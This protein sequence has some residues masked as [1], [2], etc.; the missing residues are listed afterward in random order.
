[1]AP[2]TPDTAAES[3]EAAGAPAAA[4]DDRAVAEVDGDQRQQESRGAD[5]TPAVAAP[6]AE[7]A[8]EPATTP[9]AES[10][11]EF[12]SVPP[13]GAARSSIVAPAP[14]AQQRRRVSAPIPR[15][16]RAMPA[17]AVQSGRTLA[18]VAATARVAEGPAT[19]RPAAQRAETV[20]EEAAAAASDAMEPSDEE[21]AMPAVVAE[22]QGEAAAP[23]SPQ[24]GQRTRAARPDARPAGRGPARGP[25]PAPTERAAALRDTR[26]DEARAASRP[27]AQRE[28]PADRPAIGYL[29]PEEASIPKPPVSGGDA[30]IF[31]V[32]RST[33]LRQDNDLGA[34][35]ARRR[36][37]DRVAARP[38]EAREPATIVHEAEAEQLALHPV[39]QPA[40]EQVPRTPAGSVE[41]Q[42]TGD[43]ALL[44]RG[45]DE[46]QARHT[47]RL[48]AA[49]RQPPAAATVAGIE[50]V[51]VFVDVA[52]LLYAARYL[53]RWIDFGR[54]LDRLVAGRRLIRA[55]AYCPTDPDPSAEQSFFLP[56]KGQGYRVTTKD[57][58]TFSSGAKKADLDLDIA[59][60]IVRLVDAGA[61]DSVVLASGDGDFMPVL[62]YCSDHGV[63]V[64]VAAFSEST[65][66]ELRKVCDRF[67]NLSSMDGA[68]ARR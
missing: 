39:A 67:I 35:R 59:M 46:I 6:I 29:P 14:D 41:A 25:S 20:A 53:N 61:V 19:S 21:E 52:N 47:E 51:G 38:R 62:E 43:L 26:E 63:R 7:P 34:P 11:G 15:L 45:M 55:Q 22:A 49:L 32:G 30:A 18:P 16:H 58:R 64:E 42:A 23:V 44:L 57:Y 37:R 66:D 36:G 68:P 13:P 54:L 3:A 27:L 28:A 4:V 65:H 8:P 50:R 48:M 31:H 56:V 10:A 1:M 17:P 60:D 12:P 5:E 33:Q 2:E 40:V 24:V 9:V